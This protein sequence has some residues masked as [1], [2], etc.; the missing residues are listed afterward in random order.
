MVAVLH[1]LQDSIVRYVPAVHESITVAAAD[2]YARVAGT[3]VAML[4]MIPGT[5]NGLANL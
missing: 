2:A 1:G 4:Y 5:A 3:A